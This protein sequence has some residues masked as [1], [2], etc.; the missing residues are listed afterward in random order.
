MESCFC[1]PSTSLGF[2]GPFEPTVRSESLHLWCWLCRS[3]RPP[4]SSLCWV[5]KATKNNVEAIFHSE[6]LEMGNAGNNV[7]DTEVR[8]IDTVLTVGDFPPLF[9]QVDFEVDV[10]V[11]ATASGAKPGISAATAAASSIHTPAG[12]SS[13]VMICALPS[14]PAPVKLSLKVSVSVAIAMAVALSN[15]TLETGTSIKDKDKGKS[16][17]ADN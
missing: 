8:S 13:P 4:F 7:A 1:S 12:T 3:S 11:S 6:D 5:L 2:Q 17:K 16:N 15:D 9:E 10:N 14:K